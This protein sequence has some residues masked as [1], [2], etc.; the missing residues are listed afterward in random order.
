[1]AQSSALAVAIG[2]VIYTVIAVAGLLLVRAPW[3]RWLGFAVAVSAVAIGVGSRAG[4]VSWLAVG[5]S[6]GAITGLTGPWLRVWLRRKPAATD[7]GWEPPTLILGAIALTPLVGFASPAGLSMSHGLLAASGL[8]FAW[9]YAKAEH[10]GLWGLRV[11][12]L[13][14]ALTTIP[15]TPPFGASLILFWSLGLTA[16]AWAPGARRA[17]G[18]PTPVLPSPRP[19][20]S[21]RT[22]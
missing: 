10:W 22:P 21:R 3:A 20:R 2:F 4:V 15:A 8:L 16:V 18:R 14:A 17:L 1:M 9:G 12:V 7:L 6:L 13:P 19:P 5:V 11:V